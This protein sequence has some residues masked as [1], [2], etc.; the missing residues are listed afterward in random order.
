[1]SSAK[2]ILNTSRNGTSRNSTSQ[3]NGGTTASARPEGSQSR[4][5]KRLMTP[6]PS[7]CRRPS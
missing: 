1:M 5:E 6:A 2:L 4:G 7:R 3:A